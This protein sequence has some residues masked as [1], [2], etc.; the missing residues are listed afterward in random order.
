V[1][2]SQPMFCLALMNTRRLL[3]TPVCV[4]V[5][6]CACLSVYVC[7]QSVIRLCRLDGSFSDR[8]VNVIISSVGS[9]ISP[10]H[11]TDSV[12]GRTSLLLYP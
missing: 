11:I 8:F 12:N 1:P 5:C 10:Q 6:M 4:S 3:N 7:L 9:L 2:P